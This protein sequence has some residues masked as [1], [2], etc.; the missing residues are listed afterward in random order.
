MKLVF[1]LLL[2]VMSAIA[3]AMDSTSVDIGDEVGQYI[4][5][6]KQSDTSYAKDLNVDSLVTQSEQHKNIVF[7]SVRSD[8]F[9]LSEK[10]ISNQNILMVNS[11][12]SSDSGGGSQSTLIV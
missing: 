8:L 3:L 2:F 9:R 1:L 6:L 4:K 12:D 10:L 7:I 5:I 11:V